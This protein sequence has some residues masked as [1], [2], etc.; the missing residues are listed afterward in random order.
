[1]VSSLAA[2]K[3][4]QLTVKFSNDTLARLHEE[5]LKPVPGV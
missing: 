4:K 1:M 2:A 3:D 5:K